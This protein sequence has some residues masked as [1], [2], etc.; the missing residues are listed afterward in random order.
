MSGK[1]NEKYEFI[2][3]LNQAGKTFKVRPAGEY[4]DPETGKIKTR[5]FSIFISDAK[6]FITL[7]P[8]EV[9]VLARAL[10]DKELMEQM[11]LR[12]EEYIREASKYIP[13]VL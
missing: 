7:E 2:A 3:S 4:T 12:A 10:Q 9:C 11:S 8:L 6:S 5:K 1:I 13:K